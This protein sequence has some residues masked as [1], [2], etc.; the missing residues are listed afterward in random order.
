MQTHI[1]V[2]RSYNLRVCF[3]RPLAGCFAHLLLPVHWVIHSLVGFSTGTYCMQ[4]TCSGCLT[5]GWR[6]STLA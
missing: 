4:G 5:T 2:R 1:Q 3:G 6:T